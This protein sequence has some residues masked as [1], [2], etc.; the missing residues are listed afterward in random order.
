MG[1]SLPFGIS[2]NLLLWFIISVEMS[3]NTEAGNAAN[4]ICDYTAC[5][6]LTYKT[7]LNGTTII[8]G[9]CLS[10]LTEEKESAFCFVNEDSICPKTSLDS[11][12]GVFTS[13]EPCKDPRAPKPRF[14]AALW[15]GIKWLFA[16]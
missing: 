12:P 9:Q 7:E 11:F 6:G 2:N 3:I 10:T 5:N 15:K 14:W 16:Q 1:L 13:S 4:D 8:I